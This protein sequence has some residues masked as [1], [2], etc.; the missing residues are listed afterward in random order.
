MIAIRV[1]DDGDAAAFRPIDV[2][3]EGDVVYAL[4]DGCLRGRAEA[5]QRPRPDGAA[6][7]AWIASVRAALRP[8]VWLGAFDSERLIGLASLRYRLRGSTAQLTTLHVDRAY[9]RRGV[10]RALL[11]KVIALA[12]RRGA[13][14]LYV[15]ATPSESAVS[16]YLRHGFVPAPE[17]DPDLLALEPE[18][19]HMLCPLTGAGS[20]RRS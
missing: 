9:R 13:S 6:W 18:D 5:W 17:P 8:D 16:F 4:V 12:E 11:A 14:L 15:S 7:V 10:A 20:G 1:L 19:I 2:S 3:E